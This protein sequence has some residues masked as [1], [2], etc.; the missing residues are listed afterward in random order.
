MDREN[1][2]RSMID[3]TVGEKKAFHFPIVHFPLIPWACFAIYLFGR[4]SPPSTNTPLAMFGPRLH[5]RENGLHAAL[6]PVK[7]ER[8]MKNDSPRASKF[9]TSTL[10]TRKSNHYFA[11]AVFPSLSEEKM[12]KINNHNPHPRHARIDSP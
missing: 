10:W 9:W 7:T 11:G 8:F 4:L 1:N 6:G 12:G 3:R 5:N 2:D